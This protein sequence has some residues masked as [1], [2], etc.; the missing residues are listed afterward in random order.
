MKRREAT[1]YMVSVA[2]EHHDG[3]N[4]NLTRL[5]EDCAD[6]FG[7]NHEGGPLDDETHE[8]WEWAIDAADQYERLRETEDD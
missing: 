1:R 3:C 2:E 7:C 8:I 4:V 5:A 6:H